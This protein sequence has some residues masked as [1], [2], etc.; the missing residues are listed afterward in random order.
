MVFL[1]VSVEAVG[2]ISWHPVQPLTGERPFATDDSV[3]GRS[4]PKVGDGHR[5]EAMLLTP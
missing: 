4:H 2:G 3:T 1:D 5:R